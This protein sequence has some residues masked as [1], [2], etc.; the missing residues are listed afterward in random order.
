M[1]FRP[2]ATLLGNIKDTEIYESLETY[3]EVILCLNFQTHFKYFLNYFKLLNIILIYFK[4][5][6]KHI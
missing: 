5:I 6:F 3:E 1:R 4:I 2:K